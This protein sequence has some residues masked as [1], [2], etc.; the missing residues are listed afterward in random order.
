MNILQ[1][2]KWEQWRA[3]TIETKEPE[4][5]AWI[6][7]FNAGSIF[8]D[9]GANIGIYTLWAAEKHEE[10]GIH[11]FAFEPHIFNFRHLKENVEKNQYTHC[12][13][14]IFA[15]VADKDGVAQF[16]MRNLSAGSSG[17]QLIYE[18]TERKGMY[19]VPIR[20]VD[21]YAFD[22]DGKYF[23][24]YI[25]IDVDG[26]EEKIVIGMQKTLQ[27]PRLKSVL[28]EINGPTDPIRKMFIAAGFTDNNKYTA[29][30]RKVMEDYGKQGYRKAYNAIFTRK[31]N[32]FRIIWRYFTGR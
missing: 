18:S 6:N 22:H 3:N 14:T 23:P 32:F 10:H 11:I 27:D 29:M 31:T 17:G 2:T 15:G 1:T 12:V 21:S 7:D 28:I 26:Q 25:K 4:T 20:S 16:D 24:N 9:I 13:F 19:V 5:I 8:Y 30:S